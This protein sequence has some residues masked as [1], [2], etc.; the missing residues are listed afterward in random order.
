MSISS[1]EQQLRSFLFGV[2]AF[3]F[4]GTVAELYLLEHFE[5]TR[6]W[7]PIILSV[8]G[9]TLCTAAWWKPNRTLYWGIRW[10]MGL[11]ALASLYGMYLHFMGNYEFTLEINPSFSATEAIWPAIK[12]SYPL[13]APGILF[14]GAILAL[15]ATYRHPVMKRQEIPGD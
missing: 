12:G 9:S 6:Q 4:I 5:E 15:A 14:L 13:L 10:L 3:I 11:I 2:A 7:I 8:A 1:A